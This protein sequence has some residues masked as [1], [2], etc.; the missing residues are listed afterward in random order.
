MDIFRQRYHWNVIHLG[1]KAH[2]STSS[3]NNSPFVQWML[4]CC[5]TE[6]FLTKSK[7]TNSGANTDSFRQ[8]QHGSGIHFGEKV[9]NTCSEISSPFLQWIL[10]PPFQITRSKFELKPWRV[11][12]NGGST[13][14]LL[15]HLQSMPILKI[16]LQRPH[17][18][19]HSATTDLQ[20][21]WGS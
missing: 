21:Q 19:H 2:T 1:D 7:D 10:L 15:K 9:H 6:W 4:L 17:T 12:W 11:I 18:E 16:Y 13:C 3:G 14:V 5:L 20:K 8:Y